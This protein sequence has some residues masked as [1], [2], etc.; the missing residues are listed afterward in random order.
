MLQGYPADIG[1][2]RFVAF[3]FLQDRGFGFLFTLGLAVE[4]VLSF[5]S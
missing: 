2:L 5:L 3:A 4:V 1:P